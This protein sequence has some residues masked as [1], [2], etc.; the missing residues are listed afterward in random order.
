MNATPT[1]IRALIPLTVTL[2]SPLHHGAGVSGNT[3]ILRTQEGV[4][5]WT[6]ED[7]VVPFVSGNSLRHAIR[8]ACA[9][10]TLA[11]V[12]AKLGSLSKPMVDLLYSGGA[13]ASP[14]TPQVDIEAHRRLDG[15]WAPAGLL[16]YASRGQ[17]WAGSLYVQMLLPVCA[18]NTWRMPHHP[19]LI[20]HPHASRP[21]ASLCNEDFGTRH[22]VVGSAADRFLD[23]GLWLGLPDKDRTTQMIHERPVIKAGT[24][25]YGAFE[26]QGATVAHAQ[27]L[28]VAWEWLTSTGTLHLGAGRAQGYGLCRAEADW[29]QLPDLDVD[30]VAT[31]QQH[32]DEV[33][34]LLAKAAGK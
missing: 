22:D 7:F 28:R 23:A 26:L 4:N 8:H 34:E 19:H 30:F 9:E 20:N 5:P 32:R 27:A 24:V 2:L 1:R 14:G 18:E 29:S 17:I 31:L 13:L 15:S 33:M 16:G 6:G 10:V 21:A 25:L 11:A 12:E 3:A